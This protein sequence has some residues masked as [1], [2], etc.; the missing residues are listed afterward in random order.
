[1]AIAYLPS[2]GGINK[3]NI[4]DDGLWYGD[5]IGGKILDK[6]KVK[7]YSSTKNYFDYVYANINSSSRWF[8][9]DVTEYNFLNGIT[10]YRCIYIGSDERFKESEIIGNISCSYSHNGPPEVDGSLTIDMAYDGKYTVFNSTD[11]TVLETE[12]DPTNILK[13]RND[14]DTSL[15]YVEPL[16][17]GEYIKLWIRM[18]FAKNSSLSLISNYDYFISIKDITIPMR[19]VD[20]RLSTSKVFGMALGDENLVLRETLPKDFVGKNIYKIIDKGKYINLFYIEDEQFKLLIVNPSDNPENSK[21]LTVNISKFIDGL[22]IS[23]NFLSNFSQCFTVSLSGTDSIPI[24]GNPSTSGSSNITGSPNSFFIENPDNN[25]NYESVIGKKFLVDVHGTGKLDRN[26]FYLFFNTFLTDTEQEYITKYGHRN[27]YWNC[28]IYH[29]NLSQVNDT[30]FANVA[31]GY[32]NIT[33]IN[34]VEQYSEILSNRFFI[35][36]VSMQDDV[37]AGV[38]YIPEDCRVNNNINKMFYIV[39]GD[40]VNKKPK[41]QMFDIPTTQVS[42]INTVKNKCDNEGVLLFDALRSNLVNFGYYRETRKTVEGVE[43]VQ[44]GPAGQKALHHGLSKV[45]YDGIRENIDDFC[46]TWSFGVSLQSINSYST[47]VVGYEC[48]TEVVNSTLP[49]SATTVVTTFNENN[50]NHWHLVMKDDYDDFVNGATLKIENNFINEYIPIFNI[51]CN[52]NESL[53]IMKGDYNFRNNRW[54]LTIFD[55][56]GIENIINIDDSPLFPTSENTITVNTFRK[57]DY[58]CAKKYIAYLEVWVNGTNLFNGVSYSRHTSGTFVIT[59]NYGEKFA[60]WLSYWDV[61]KHIDINIGK[62]SDTMFRLLSNIAWSE[63]ESE[64]I[65]TTE[66][67]SLKMFN[68]KRNILIKNLKWGCEDSMVIPVV[69]QGSGYDIGDEYNYEVRRNVFDFTKVDFSKK[70]FAFTIEGISELL[71]WTTDGYDIERDMMTIWVRVNNWDGQRIIMYYSDNMIMNDIKQ[72]NPYHSD[73]YAAWHMNERFKS[74]RR[75]FIDQGIYHAGNYYVNVKD[76]N[77]VKYLIELNEQYVFG[78]IN[79]YMSNKFDIKWDDSTVDRKNVDL[80][81]EFIRTH[82]DKFKPSFME[83]RNAYPTLPYVVE[84]GGNNFT[85]RDKQPESSQIV[86]PQSPSN[87]CR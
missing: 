59:H 55:E 52:G 26:D 62:Y 7:R 11:S 39:E 63:L 37:I 76:S 82:I 43:Y 16:K 65:N 66:V 28:G 61:R 85:V 67:E 70:S 40:V 41:M 21:Y 33:Q 34:L 60:G 29:I 83:L 4:T 51:H 14:W 50:P 48:G 38:G 32:G 5:S 77:N 42:V 56:T 10:V 87:V 24:T 36:S 79:A 31:P 23:N 13:S 2:E 19:R 54:N 8:F 25:Q 18:R 80:I 12:Q 6:I 9:K 45:S 86:V 71:E 49:M 47:P 46:S 64:N 22:T 81:N 30:F 3:V 68:Y 17:P 73:W 35:K 78:L 72:S 1:M 15:T 20:G 74:P 57:M 69:L 27:F 44:M 84:G 58:G 75:R 53:S